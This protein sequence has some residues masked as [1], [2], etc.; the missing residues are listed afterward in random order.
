MYDPHEEHA[1]QEK[2]N[3]DEVAWNKCGFDDGVMYQNVRTLSTNAASEKIESL[4][5]VSVGKR[6]RKFLTYTKCELEFE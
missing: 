5:L 3:G 6:I 1:V 2:R 4:I